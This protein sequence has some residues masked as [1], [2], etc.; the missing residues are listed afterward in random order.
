MFRLF[1]E[2]DFES[3]GRKKKRKEKERQKEKEKVWNY[4]IY[5]IY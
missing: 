3:K 1:I 2:K 5:G 4:D